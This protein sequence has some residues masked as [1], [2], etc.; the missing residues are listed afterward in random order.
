M[1][2]FFRSFFAALLALVVFMI[3]LFFFIGGMISG[4]SKQF[5]KKEATVKVNSVLELNLNYS[6]PEQTQENL[7]AGLSLLSLS[8]DNAIGLNDILAS[9]KHAEKD[10]NIKGIYIRLGLNPNSS[11]TL[12]EVRDALEDFKKNSGKFVIAYGEV[13]NQAAYFLG[14]VGDA[15]YLNPSGILEFK[16]YSAQVSFYK[17]ALDKLGVKTQIFY[18][19]KFKSATE[20]FR[21][22][23]MSDEN[24]LQLRDYL[25]SLFVHNLSEISSTRNIGT[26]ELKNIANNLSGWYPAFA[27]QVG[28][29][30]DVLYE[31]EVHDI[32]KSKIGLNTT[33]TVTIIS[34]GKYS[35]TF[36][37]LNPFEKTVKEKIAVVYAD[38]T[39]IDGEGESGYI[40]SKTFADM[41][42]EAAKDENIKAI[43]LRVNSP[44]G[45]AVASDVMWRSIE[46]A[47]EK[48]PVIVSMGSY[49]A[50]GGYMISCN[51]DR[52]FAEPNTLTGSIGVF[53]IVPEISDLMNDKIGISF[54]TVNTSAHADFPSIT[55]EFDDFEKNILQQG[56]DSTYDK[57]KKMVADGR[58]LSMDQVESVA[59]G[60]IWIGLKAKELGLVD[61]IGGIDETI[62]YAVS[63]AGLKEYSIVEFPKQEET[64][65]TNILH[66]MTEE[67]KT[68]L[69]A[70]KLGVFYPH[71]EAVTKLLE[72]PL[73]Q[74]RLPYEII[75]R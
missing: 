40:G 19:G 41:M 29:V 24:R 51:A 2:D 21:M 25:N 23:K 27:R 52:I 39:I 13:I 38:G 14:S 64:F 9:I 72:K 26:E 53:L 74:A 34:L 68:K 60:R 17:E 10:D 43:V 35:S 28:L 32:L 36:Q 42:N 48:K 8:F 1:K 65:F 49:A 5:E 31:D 22:E 59:Q 61:E 33:D 30:N 50:S 69:L 45:S 12:Q 37:N 11:A 56:V 4:L 55:R 15:V 63:Q 71:Y 67:T 57:F 62:A 16:G 47:K 54:D 58:G 73:M 44:G 3:L 18:D 46:K 75:I 66:S 6:I 70:D 20:P 7:A